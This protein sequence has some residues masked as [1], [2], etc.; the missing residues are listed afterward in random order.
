MTEIKNK[1]Y[2]DELMTKSKKF[3]QLP[4]KSVAAQPN[5]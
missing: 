4:Y 2:N 3:S 5:E 1:K